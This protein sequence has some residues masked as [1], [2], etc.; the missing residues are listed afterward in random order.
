MG[1]LDHPASGAPA[2]RV[3][4]L[5]DLLAASADVRRQVVA[6]DQLADLGVVVC[7]VQADALRVL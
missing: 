6:A 7:L 4:L 1:G 2:R 5:G 3:D